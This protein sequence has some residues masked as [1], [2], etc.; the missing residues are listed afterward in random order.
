MKTFLKV[1]ICVLGAEI[2]IIRQQLKH[3]KGTHPMWGQLYD[4]L[5]Q[6]NLQKDVRAAGIAYGFLRGHTYTQVENK[7]Y[8]PPDWKR[9]EFHV[10]R[11]GSGYIKT[12]VDPRDLM[13][14]FSAWLDEAKKTASD[15]ACKMARTGRDYLAYTRRVNYH[16]RFTRPDPTD[17][18][19]LKAQL[20]AKWE[21]QRKHA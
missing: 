7:C 12:G 6:H 3:W 5:K 16:A 1:K 10:E 21:S 14:R 17:Q 18:K 15:E 4:H 19:A 11:F 20:K 9:V 2:R 13:Q 8:F